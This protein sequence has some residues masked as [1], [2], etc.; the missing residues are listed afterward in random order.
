[1][2]NIYDYETGNELAS[3]LQGCSVCDEAIQA[4]QR[5][6]DDRGT[7]V[8]LW[9]DDGRWLVHPARADDSRPAADYLGEEK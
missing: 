3:G 2:A 9:D 7:P 5:F 8:E 4:A 1:M 6:A